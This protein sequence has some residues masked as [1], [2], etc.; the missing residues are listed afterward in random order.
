M[1]TRRFFPNGS[2][3]TRSSQKL[4]VTY[5][6]TVDKTTFVQFTNP[7]QTSQAEELGKNVA[8]LLAPVRNLK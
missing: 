2:E 4:G 6:D 8:Q 1:V 5:H 7:R 3:A